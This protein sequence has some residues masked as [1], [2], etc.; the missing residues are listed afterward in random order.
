M[1]KYARRVLGRYAGSI[2]VAAVVAV[3]LVACGGGS[4]SPTSPTPAPPTPT[5]PPP[6]TKTTENPLGSS[7]NV[8]ARTSQAVP[9]GVGPGATVFDDFTFTG[10]ANIT[11]VSW[12]GIYCREV[13]NAA[14]PAPTATAFIIAFYA[15]QAGRP[16]AAAP[17]YQITVPISSVNEM[18]DRNQANLNCG[19]TPT[20]WAFYSYST[21]LPTAFGAEAGRKYWMSIQAQVPTQQPFWGWRDGIVD[22]RLSVQLFQGAFTDFPVDRAYGLGQ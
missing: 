10:G 20:T 16:N 11:R 3:T 14:A 6:T 18:L 1:E 4:K 21:V 17:L 12:Q 19:T 15:D 7:N 9:A 8:E 22:N 2:C 13:A 5:P